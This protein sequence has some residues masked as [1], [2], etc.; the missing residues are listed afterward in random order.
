MI[1]RESWTQPLRVEKPGTTQSLPRLRNGH[2]TVDT[3]R[4][5]VWRL[6]Y[7]SERESERQRDVGKE[8]EFDEPRIDGP[9]ARRECSTRRWG[10][11][12]DGHGEYDRGRRRVHAVRERRGRWRETTTDGK[13]AK[14]TQANGE[15]TT[16][17]RRTDKTMARQRIWA[18]TGNGLDARALAANGMIMNVVIPRRPLRRLTVTTRGRSLLLLLFLTF[19][20]SHYG[21]EKASLAPRR[22]RHGRENVSRP[23]R[24]NPNGIPRLAVWFTADF[25]PSDARRTLCYHTRNQINRFKFKL[26]R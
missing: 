11:H 24:F 14:T 16:I 6:G 20:S 2:W 18:P 15:R 8:H 23:R 22:G 5:R 17:G 3:Y 19:F 26:V 1:K 25:G 4:P 13:N 12:R 21:F 7:E 9:D 10:V